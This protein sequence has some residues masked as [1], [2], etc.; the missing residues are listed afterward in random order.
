M[1]VP[2]SST[3]AD[4][5]LMIIYTSGTTGRPKGAVHSH[6]GF[7]IKTAQDMVHCFDVHDG[8]TMYWVSD[9]GW[10]MG[11]WE[12][13]GMT[14]LG[15]TIVLYD[16]ALD[17]PAPGSPLGTR[18]AAS[19]QHPR[20]LTHSHSCV[21]EARRRPGSRARSRPRFASSGRP[22]SPGIPSP[23]SGSSMSSVAAACR[24]STTREEPRC[25]AGS[26]QATS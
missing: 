4:D 23:G 24:S 2:L 3:G 8:E 15:G 18:R 19:R 5:P 25:P 14:L 21:D 7:P 26:S 11:P 13:F 10:M 20:R 9:M 6:C 22:A 16:G 17:F 12:V 1:S